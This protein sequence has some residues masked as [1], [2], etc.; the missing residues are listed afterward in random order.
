MDD[1]SPQTLG[2]WMVL[3]CFIGLAQQTC[4]QRSGADDLNSFSGARSSPLLCAADI[5]IAMV[6]LIV[7]GRTHRGFRASAALYIRNTRRS[8][9]V[10]PPLRE[11]VHLLSISSFIGAMIAGVKLFSAQH[12]P[13]L[14]YVAAAVYFVALLFHIL[15]RMIG[16]PRVNEDT[17]AW[18]NTDVDRRL[19]RYCDYIWCFAYVLQFGLWVWVFRELV[20]LPAFRGDNP[21]L[22]NTVIGLM[23]ATA[24]SISYINIGRQL[25]HMWALQNWRA[26]EKRIA[27]ITIVV[28][29]IATGLRSFYTVAILPLAAFSIVVAELW[30]LSICS[31]LFGLLLQWLY[32]GP[33]VGDLQLE[34]ADPGLADRLNPLLRTAPT[35]WRTTLSNTFASCNLTFAALYFAYLYNEG[36]GTMQSFEEGFGR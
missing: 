24:I 8:E 32:N 14:V 22:T 33:A 16:Q 9:P 1:N 26:R 20:A 36:R 15:L 2:R 7:G 29:V 25:Y 30:T 17:T 10:L 28:V 11:D 13:V 6:T 35:R 23:I 27:G 21:K 31:R 4:L 5:I 12:A 34:Q 3:W 19:L 18:V